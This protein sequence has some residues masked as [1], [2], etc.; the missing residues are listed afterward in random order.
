L[1]KNLQGHSAVVVSVRQSSP[2]KPTATVPTKH[3]LIPAVTGEEGATS[4]TGMVVT[5]L[6]NKTTA[7]IQQGI[8]SVITQ[9]IGSFESTPISNPSGG[10]AQAGTLFPVNT[11]P[12]LSNESKTVPVD[13]QLQTPFEK[14]ISTIQDETGPPHQDKPGGL[15]E[16]SASTK[17]KNS[18]ETSSIVKSEKPPTQVDT[19][20]MEPDKPDQALPTPPVK[21]AQSLSRE[22]RRAK[23]RQSIKRLDTL[24]AE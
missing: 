3:T 2:R 18:S 23:L 21:D 6:I 4:F 7:G 11:Q 17:I 9:T 8:N 20:K 22:E 19:K 5:D 10:A 24:L 16:K 1:R 13:K 15:P 12:K 14:Q